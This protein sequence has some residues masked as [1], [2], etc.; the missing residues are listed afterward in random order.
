MD[1]RD[2]IRQYESEQSILS[3]INIFEQ[4]NKPKYSNDTSDDEYFITGYNSWLRDE[5]YT[6]NGY[7]KEQNK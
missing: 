7:P 2:R 3:S 5:E 6:I 4:Q 1:I